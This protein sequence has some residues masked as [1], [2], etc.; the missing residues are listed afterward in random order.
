MWLLQGKY[1]VLTK[2]HQMNSLIVLYRLRTLCIFLPKG[3]PGFRKGFD[4]Q[5][6]SARNSVLT[7]WKQ[8]ST[9]DGQ[10]IMDEHSSF[11]TPQKGKFEFTAVPIQSLRDLQ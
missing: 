3:V 7:L 2:M 5:M 9:N 8:P 6:E 11:L 1:L 10:E 4:P